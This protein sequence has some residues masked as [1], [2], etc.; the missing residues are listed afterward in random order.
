MNS[1]KLILKAFSFLIALVLVFTMAPLFTKAN[2]DSKGNEYPIVLVHGLAGWGRDEALGIKYWGG[3]KDLEKILN[4]KG[5]NFLTATVGP[6]S[7]NWDRSVELYYYIKG[8]TV[9]Y[10][11][12]HATKHGHSR[13]GKTFKGIYPE[14]D[15]NKPVHLVGHSMGGL[16]VRGLTDLLKDGSEEEIAYH[17]LH[18]ELGEVS[19]LFKG[20]QDLVHSVTSLATPHDGTTFAD[21]DSLMAQFIKELVLDAAAL[22]GKGTNAFVYDFKLDQWGIRRNVGETFTSYLNRVM[23]SQIWKSKDISLTDLSTKGAIENN[24][25]IDTHEDIYYFSYSAQTTNRLLLTGYHV[26]NALTNPI[27]ILPSKYIGKFTRKES[28]AGPKIDSSWWPNDGIVN[29]RSSISPGGQPKVNYNGKNPRIGTWNAYPV[30]QNWDH[31]D[32]MG[33]NPLSYGTSYDASVF[34]TK[35]A[36]NLYALP[37]RD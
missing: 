26:P 18:P 25:W 9:D 33:A 19:D 16:T 13:Y 3:V 8:G 22:T 27:F 28:A 36:Q 1:M 7:S 12:A 20:G 6:V 35:M 11:A 29:T 31:M 23:S 32:Y 4:N 15:G 37:E 17:K 10:G 30:V 14:W 21:D 5:Y 24:K 34:L 2:G